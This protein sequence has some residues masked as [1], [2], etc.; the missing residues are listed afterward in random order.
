MYVKQRSAQ[1]NGDN[2]LSTLTAASAVAHLQRLMSISLCKQQAPAIIT[3][4][5]AGLVVLILVL[6]PC[7]GLPALRVLIEQLVARVLLVVLLVVVGC[8]FWALQR[9]ISPVVPVRPKEVNQDDMLVT[10]M[11][12][13]RCLLDAVHDAR[14]G[15]QDSRKTV[16]CGMPIVLVGALRSSSNTCPPGKDA[17]L[18]HLYSC[19]PCV[20]CV[21]IVS[22]L[23]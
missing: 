4:L 2:T 23:G 11:H 14:P 5:Y 16:L 9:L 15:L 21:L 22:G 17:V 3:E 12:A 6:V 20:Q 19:A 1:A 18:A 8:G 7:T 10:L 13:T